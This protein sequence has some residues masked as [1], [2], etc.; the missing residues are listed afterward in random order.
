MQSSVDAQVMQSLPQLHP[1]P[2]APAT[3]ESSLVD[4]LVGLHCNIYF[5]GRVTGR[6]KQ[7]VL[8]WGYFT[9]MSGACVHFSAITDNE[10]TEGE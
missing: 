9:L 8:L 3:H 6:I 5:G 1:T 2:V 4:G 7:V 10:Q